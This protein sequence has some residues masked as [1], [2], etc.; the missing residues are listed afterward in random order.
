[1]I[2]QRKDNGKLTNRIDVNEHLEDERKFIYDWLVDRATC[3]DDR[4]M[5]TL[6][7]SRFMNEAMAEYGRQFVI[8]MG[9]ESKKKPSHSASLAACE[10]LGIKK[11]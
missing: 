4:N 8:E 9:V 1:V 11:K 2:F 5:I 3:A 10:I 7:F 6:R